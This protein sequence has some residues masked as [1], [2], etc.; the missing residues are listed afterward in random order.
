MWLMTTGNCKPTQLRA[1][2]SLEWNCEGD[3]VSSV[4]IRKHTQH[5]EHDY[6]KLHRILI[7]QQKYIFSFLQQ[8]FRSVQRLGYR[9]G[10]RRNKFRFRAK[11][12][13][14][15]P[16]LSS[17]M[18]SEVKPVCCSADTGHCFRVVQETGVWSRTTRR[19]ES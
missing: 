13:N 8:I 9:L 18:D 11:A 2:I 5:K 6:S 14:L 10:S 1:R 15:F 12:L 17:Q 16:S 3:R 7:L 19:I 4:L